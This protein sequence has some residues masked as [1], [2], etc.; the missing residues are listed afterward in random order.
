MESQKRVVD[1][2]YIE[3]QKDEATVIKD[4]RFSLDFWKQHLKVLQEQCFEQHFDSAAPDVLEILNMRNFLGKFLQSRLDWIVSRIKDPDLRRKYLKVLPPFQQKG[5]IKTLLLHFYQM[6]ESEDKKGLVYRPKNPLE[7]EIA[8]LWDIY[9]LKK[10]IES[11]E[12]IY[13]TLDSTPV[14]PSVFSIENRSDCLNSLKKAFQ[15]MFQMCIRKEH[16]Q[17]L[18]RDISSRLVSPEAILEWAEA[19]ESFV[20]PH[21]L[22]KFDYRNHFFYVYYY[23]GMKAK[24]GG[25]IKEFRFNYLDFE[26]I[27]QEFLI[28]WMNQRLKGNP[29]K[30]VVYAKYSLGDKTIQQIVAEHP[31]REIEVLQQLPISVFNDITAEVNQEVSSDL[32]T[33]VEAFS[34]NQGQFA[35]DAAGFVQATSIAKSSLQKLKQLVSKKKTVVPVVP[36]PEP[37]P[38]PEVP[39][40]ETPVYEVIKIKKNQIDFPFFHKETGRYKQQLALLR[41]KMGDRFAEFSRRMSQFFVNVSETVLIRRRTPKH[42]VIYPNLIKETKGEQVTH[43]LLILG[44]EVKAKQLSMAYGAKSGEGAYAFTCFF[45]YGC[46]QA[47]PTLGEARDIRHARGIDFHV[48]DFAHPAVLERAFAFYQLVMEKKG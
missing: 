45:V 44:A 25:K 30:Q 16:Q 32:K 31:E 8:V 23:P 20:Y 33:D 48:F 46:D 36:E 1:L 41:V 7:K 19:G 43:H 40:V 42:E 35:K 39:I 22:Q 28:D 6:G 11:I 18:Y 2:I 14:F 15:L 5:G 21:V 13:R 3:P 10:T 17:K 29:K 47:D 34:E 4:Y 37:E 12:T 27:K 38:E 24:I 9:K 26:I